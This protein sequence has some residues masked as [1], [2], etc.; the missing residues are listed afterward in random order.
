MAKNDTVIKSYIDK[1]YEMNYKEKPV[2]ILRFL[3]DPYFLGVSTWNKE[4]NVSSIYPYWRDALVKIFEDSSKL[5]IVLT[6]SIGTGKST[7]GLYGLAYIQYRLLS[8]KSPWSYFNL[9]DSGKMAVSFFNLNKSLGQ[10]RGFHKLSSLM[11]KSPWFRKQASFISKAKDLEILEFPLIRH[12]LSSP[13]S[14]GFGVLGEDVVA[15]IMDEIDSPQSSL[16]QKELVLEVYKSTYRRYKDRFAPKGYSLGKLFLSASKQGEGSFI[17][18]FIE[19]MKNQPEVLIFDAALW[20]AKPIKRSGVFFPVAVGNTF[21]PSKLAPIQEEIPA[22]IELDKLKMFGERH[23]EIFNNFRTAVIE[24]GYSKIIEVP[25]E[26][27]FNFEMDIVGSLRDL[28]GITVAG[29]NK[30][31]LIAAPVF[32]TNCFDRLKENPM[33]KE[34]IL[35]GLYD[36]IKLREFFDITKLRLPLNFPRAIHLDMSISGDAYG[37]AMSG[38]KDWM[39]STVQIENNMFTEANLP[40]VETDLA[41]TLKAREGDRIPLHKVREFIID[42]RQMGVNIQV[43]TA[44]LTLLS[45]SDRQILLLTGIT[46]ESLSLDKTIKPYLDFKGMIYE[47]RWTCHFIQQLLTELS[48]LEE[49]NKQGKIDH[50]KTVIK[51]IDLPDGSQRREEENGTK[52]LADAVAGSIYSIILKSPVPLSINNITETFKRINDNKLL[53]EQKTPIKLIDGHSNEEILGNKE[54]LEAQSLIELMKKIRNR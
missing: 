13:Y 45:E 48:N 17:D 27:R 53:E 23:N 50:P 28:A 33:S 14:E 54:N 42:L 10:S 21:K 26:F 6:G 11:S 25:I 29:M 44:D 1:I 22:L 47:R 7:I 39:K 37:F 24:E 46:A 4:K 3:D 20:E 9:A 35:I 36:T 31:K 32:I 43:V 19:T 16:E 40:I 2:D 38:I 18:N 8:L 30:R 49:D 5:Q 12:I 51:I 41:F 34:Q 52:D 15:G